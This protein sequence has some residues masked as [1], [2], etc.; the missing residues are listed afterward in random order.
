MSSPREQLQG[1]REYLLVLGHQGVG[2]SAGGLCSFLMLS[3]V[4]CSV[5]SSLMYSQL[6]CVQSFL[7]FVLLCHQS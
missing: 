3:R 6:L 4:I 2:L 7:L 1:P 5:E